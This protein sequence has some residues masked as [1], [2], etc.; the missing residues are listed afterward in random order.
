MNVTFGHIAPVRPIF[1]HQPP[2]KFAGADEA[3]ADSFKANDP[4]DFIRALPAQMNKREAAAL[5]K[6]AVKDPQINTAH[7]QHTPAERK[8]MATARLPEHAL[9][10]GLLNEFFRLS[11]ANIESPPYASR[12]FDP[13]TADRELFSLASRC[14]GIAYDQKEMQGADDKK[15]QQ[16]V[17]M[18]AHMAVAAS[19]PGPVGMHTAEY[20]KAVRD[21]SFDFAQIAQDL[22]EAGMRVLKQTEPKTAADLKDK[23]PHSYH[24]HEAQMHSQFGHEDRAIATLEKGLA[25]LAGRREQNEIR[26][27]LTE[28]YEQ[29]GEWQK[30]AVHRDLALKQYEDG[31]TKS[32]Y[33]EKLY[34]EA[35]IPQFELGN[36]DKA[37][38]LAKKAHELKPDGRHYRYHENDRYGQT[39]ADF[40]GRVMIAKAAK[41]G[42]S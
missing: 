33:P 6:E 10:K 25:L 3:P 14:R 41:D 36:L 5:L 21:T 11:L 27:R 38:E 4:L 24:L 32:F 40:L 20:F 2:V 13:P 22:Y 8:E 26:Q 15:I 30:A 42:G 39:Y 17:Q 12:G 31:E 34:I 37:L 1:G 23:Y 18:Y 9:K 35:A 28:H 19:Y 7:F 29:A 16:Q